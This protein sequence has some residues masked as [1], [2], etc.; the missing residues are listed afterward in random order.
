M[1]SRTKALVGIAVFAVVVMAAFFLVPAFYWF[2]GYSPE[3]S[4]H[5]TPIYTAYRS[6]GCMYLGHGDAYYTAQGLMF[7]CDF[8]VIPR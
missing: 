1:R 4:S 5:S 3:L 2:T 6:L 8:P 7:S